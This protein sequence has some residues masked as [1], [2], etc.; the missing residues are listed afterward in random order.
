[1]SK[2]ATNEHEELDSYWEC[3]R[4][5]FAILVFLL[6]FI[7]IYELC[8]LYVLSDSEGTVTNSAHEGI[9]RFF[10]VIS[11]DMLGLSLPGVA[12]VLVLLIWHI[13]L[14]ASWRVRWSALGLMFVESVLWA[15]PLLVFSRTIHHFLPLVGDQDQIITQLGPIGRIGISIGAGLYEE[16]VFR[17]LVIFVV[18]TILVDVLRLNRTA[19]TLIAIGVSAI[20]FTIYHPLGGADGSWA[21][22]RVVFYLVAGL[23][24]GGLF[25]W[26]GFGIA[27]ATHAFYDIVTMLAEN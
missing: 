11:I 22:G 14:R 25:V 16:L 12:V 26:R 9:I 18:H 17:M 7:V 19:G 6:P 24:F 8:L 27:V 13:L 21:M 3:S 1:M 15:V 20:L 5:P 2:Q 23:F 10:G 4:R